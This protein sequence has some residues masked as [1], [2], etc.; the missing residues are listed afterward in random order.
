M[1]LFWAN[2]PNTVCAGSNAFVCVVVQG[3]SQHCGPG[4]HNQPCLN[5]IVVLLWA[6]RHTGRVA[7]KEKEEKEAARQQQ[8]RAKACQER[9][10]QQQVLVMRLLPPRQQQQQ[11]R[12][13]H[14]LPLHLY[15]TLIKMFLIGW[16]MWWANRQAQHSS[17]LQHTL[18]L[19]RYVAAG[20]EAALPCAYCCLPHTQI[21]WPASIEGSSADQQV[22]LPQPTG[23]ADVLDIVTAAQRIVQDDTSP[24]S[25]APLRVMLVPSLASPGD[26]R[27]VVHPDDSATLAVWKH[28]AWLLEHV[29][30]TPGKAAALR[31]PCHVE[32][33]T[34]GSST[35]WSAPTASSTVLALPGITM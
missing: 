12:L 22:S 33:P 13:L 7:E 21:D 19:G 31:V 34:S 30:R 28:V 15:P 23:S 1:D 4:I 16:V 5:V 2:P 8:P 29:H 17:K 24:S 35:A 3:L 14:L 27:F 20:V 10:Q 25:T 6:T 9:Q 32:A 11:Q 18:L 26:R